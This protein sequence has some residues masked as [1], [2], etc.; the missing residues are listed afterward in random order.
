MWASYRTLIRILSKRSSR[1]LEKL[2]KYEIFLVI[3]LSSIL[4]KQQGSRSSTLI[5]IFLVDERSNG[6]LFRIGLMDRTV[7]TLPADLPSV[8]LTG[9]QDSYIRA[10]ESAFPE[11]GITVRGN[12]IILR[13]PRE[14]CDRVQK[15]MANFLAV[16]RTGQMLTEDA[17][18]RSKIGRAHV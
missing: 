7:L 8:A 6:L 2:L 1:S 4:G 3:E 15:L 13:G 10:I 17:V 5:S 16:V 11:I 9:P 12:E 14:S 18:R